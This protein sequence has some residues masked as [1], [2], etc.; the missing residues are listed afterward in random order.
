MVTL[1]GGGGGQA[2]LVSFDLVTD[3]SLRPAKAILLPFSLVLGQQNAA[4]SLMT[5]KAL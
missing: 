3:F 1:G 5:P 4:V 2:D